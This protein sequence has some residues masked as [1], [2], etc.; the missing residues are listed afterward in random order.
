M[1]YEP[2]KQN[3]NLKYSPLKACIAPCPIAWITTIS[4]NHEINL[5]PFSF[6]NLISEDPA[7]IMVSISRKNGTHEKDT[8]HNIMVNKEFTVNLV[9]VHLKEQMLETSAVLDYGLSE[10]TAANLMIDASNIVEPPRITGSPVSLECVLYSTSELPPNKDGDFC[11]MIIGSIVGVHIDDKFI[12]DGKVIT[13]DM[14]LV[15]R[16]G[17]NEYLTADNLYNL[18]RPK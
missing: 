17:Y 8:L 18:A 4:D 12:K 7:M 10:V 3:H 14:Q 6:F 11:T 2:S 16:L 13:K 15:A 9:P 1:F 5:A